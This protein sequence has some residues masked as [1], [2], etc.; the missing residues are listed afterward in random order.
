MRV[1]LLYN[2]SMSTEI[3]A[4]GPDDAAAVAAL[5]RETFIDTYSEFNTPQDMALHVMRNFGSDIQRREIEDDAISTVVALHDGRLL[6]YAQGQF[7]STPR[8]VATLQPAPSR[9]WEIRRF[10]VH[11]D[12]HGRG[13]A[14]QLMRGVLQ[15]AS[16]RGADAVWLGVWSRNSRAQAFYRKSGFEVIGETTFT[17]GSDPQLDFVML[18]PIAAN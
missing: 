5:A 4:A 11:R 9:P 18:K 13:I 12:A 1:R 10:Y 2:R 8:G 14:Q 6:G 17:L 3:R 16:A 7:S 15:Q